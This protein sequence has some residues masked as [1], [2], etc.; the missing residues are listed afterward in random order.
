MGC[1]GGQQ[2]AGH[3]PIAAAAHQ[4][5]C[6]GALPRRQRPKPQ[7]H[8][9]GPLHQRTL[10]TLRTS[11]RSSAMA[12]A[13][14]TRQ[15]APM[16]R[17]RWL[18]ISRLVHC[19][20]RSATRSAAT[21]HSTYGLRVQQ[22]LHRAHV[23]PRPDA[24]P[25]LLLLLL[26]G[27]RPRQGIPAGPGSSPAGPAAGPAA[28]PPQLQAQAGSSCHAAHA[29]TSSSCGDSQPRCCAAVHR[30]HRTPAGIR[31]PQPFGHHPPYG[32]GRGSTGAGLLLP[33]QG[34][35][36]GRRQPMVRDAPTPAPL[37]CCLA[38]RTCASHQTPAHFRAACLTAACHGCL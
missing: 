4:Q 13:P 31:R 1:P 9:A 36:K 22:A 17:P 3:L 25:M 19:M 16:H 23:A 21:A 11:P 38:H 12:A 30:L 2:H 33:A 20:Q 27:A 35:R 10:R 37:V 29:A 32:A 18:S 7:L 14:S 15:A 24:R 5:R 26:A 6:T 28:Q 8:A 34:R